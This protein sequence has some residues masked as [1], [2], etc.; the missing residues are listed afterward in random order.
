M[1]ALGHAYADATEAAKVFIREGL[2]VDEVNAYSEA[3]L[4]LAERL[5]VDVV[6]AA[7]LLNE[8]NIGGLEQ[9]DELQTKTGDLTQAEYD[10]ARA[11][12]EAGDA[13]QARQ[14]I[15]DAVARRNAEIAQL[16]ESR[17]TPAVNSLRN[18][19]S[20]LADFL[21]SVLAGRLTSVKAY[22]DD[23]AIG[24]AYVFGLLS[25][26]GFD[27]AMADARRAFDNINSVG[28]AAGG[29]SPQQVRDT[30]FAATLDDEIDQTRD[31]TNAERL[32]RAE[33]EARTRAQEAGVSA[34]LQERAVTQAIAAEQRQINQEGA[35][36][37]RR[38]DAAA[39]RAQRAAQTAER[40]RQT[41]LR[42]L[43][44][45]VRQ[46]NRATFTGASAGLEER[47]DAINERYE[48]IAD[49]IQRVRDLGLTADSDGVSLTDLEA[50]AAVSQQRLRDE[51]TIKFYQEQAAL[52]DQQRTDEL[53]RITDAQVRGAISTAEA[54]TQADEV[55][56]RLSPQIV[57]AAES[58]LTVARALAGTNPS[59][60][61]VSWIASL[62]RII[63]GETS[64][65]LVADIGLGGLEAESR[66]LD[67]LLRQR[68]EL[69]SGFETLNDL[70]LRTAVQ[71][72]DST[73]AVFETQAAAIRPVL[74]QLRATVEAL[75]NQIDPLTNLPVLTDT[76][77]NA[78]LIKIEA[79]NAGLAQT[80]TRLSQLENTALQGV[81]QG[82]VD[83]FN[84]LSKG[85]AGFMMGTQSLGSVFASVGASI[86]QTM[87]QI[88]AAIA[89]AIIKFLILRAL[90]TAAGLP[91]GTLSGQGGGGGGQA[92]MLGGLFSLFHD[93]GVV[94]KQG[95]SRQRRT[96]AS[97]LSWI[98]AP[99]FH[100]GG[101]PGLRPDEYR[102]VVQRGEEILTEDNPRHINNA[103]QGGSEG[104]GMGGIKQVLLLDPEAVPNA[105]QGRAGQK[106][107]LTVIRQNKETIK[108]VLR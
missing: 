77:Y 42:Q 107:M 29:S 74:D 47:L 71:T 89:Q 44:S 94:G 15:L 4:T 103:G 40:A 41:A 22:L 34:A 53:E 31:L 65:R 19:F 83:A 96:G 49:S 68:D 7:N 46:L 79:T 8:V 81:A 92:G 51:E 59:P 82:G 104:G 9:L 66:Q 108:Q 48:T 58:A 54:M 101:M 98:G 55:V 100:G 5:G 37:G 105:M 84:A 57:Q 85:L 28:P 43:D 63:S 6:E 102:A 95:G 45:Q 35:R 21:A 30:Q 18:A 26:R 62:E 60:E 16:T 61:M 93:G 97:S 99:K 13:A 32:A 39:N 33:R 76:A 25:G 64:N 12:F 36:A 91:P 11:L 75:H 69:V 52:L 73:A 10:H 17:W 24:A 78:W 3:A 88:T 90:E 56:G 50:Q 23:L 87:A 27:G 67:E 38:S 2:P 80:S 86:L 20:N 14:Y 70:G 72:R 1:A 106:A